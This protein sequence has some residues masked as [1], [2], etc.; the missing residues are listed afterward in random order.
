MLEEFQGFADRVGHGDV[1][2]ITRVVSFD[3]QT[4]VL[5]PRWVD[6]DGV[7]IPERIEEAGGVVSGKELGTEVVYGKGEGGGKGCVGPK[8]GSVRHRSVAVEL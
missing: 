8:T 5:S 1:N 7:I 2:V 6:G 3:G 4:A